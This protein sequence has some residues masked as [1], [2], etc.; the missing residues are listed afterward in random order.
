M[1]NHKNT[2]IGQSLRSFLPSYC[3][4]CLGLTHED[5][6][7]HE[8]ECDL[9]YL[10]QAA[11][12]CRTCS[13]PAENQDY[14]TECLAFP[15]NFAYSVIPFAYQFPI[16]A[17][18]T[19]FKFNGDLLAGKILTHALI[20]AV[21][22]AYQEQSYVFPDCILPIPANRWQHCVRG[23]NQAEILAQ[24]LSQT[25]AIPYFHQVLI[26]GYRHQTQHQRSRQER[27]L[28]LQNLYRLNPKAQ[29]SIRNKRIGLVDDVVT[30]CATARHVSQ[31]LLQAGAAEVHL[32]AI[33]RT[34]KPSKVN[35]QL[36]PFLAV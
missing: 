18:V 25:L 2:S 32:W 3:Y 6:L 19:R 22:G 11:P 28:Q 36:K 12:L 1:Q 10:V 34:L 15:P 13:L 14:C 24:G 35:C 16:D 17:L 23:F 30:T 5:S 9:P 29:V 7:C 27:F 26:R 31:L 8:C 20:E 33:A 21:R 4:L